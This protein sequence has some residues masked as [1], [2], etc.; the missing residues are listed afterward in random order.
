SHRK[1]ENELP[2]EKAARLLSGI[3]GIGLARGR[4]LAIKGA[5]T[6]ED[7]KRPEYFSE[8]TEDQRIGLKYYED[9]LSRIPR[10]EV[11]K[12]YEVVLD[13]AKRVDPKLQVECMGSYRRRQPDSGDIDILVTRDP[14]LDGKTHS[15]A[16]GKMHAILQREGFFQH[17]LSQ[18]DDWSDLTCKVNGLCQLDENSKM[19][20]IDILGVPWDDMPAAMIYFTGNDHYNRSLRLKA[21]HMGYSLNQKCLSKSL[22]RDSKGEKM[23]EGTRVPGIKTERDIFRILKVPYKKPEERIPS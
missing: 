7:L 8:L 12:L 19:R 14:T 22:I 20:R 5:K 1:L 16:I 15:G 13:A 2:Q 18:S 6:V 10:A 3:Y 11:T 23:T 21:R 4:E 9:L 17:I